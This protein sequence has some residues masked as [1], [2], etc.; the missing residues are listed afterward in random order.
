M[1]AGQDP[2]ASQ[3]PIRV[4]PL[5]ETADLLEA[6]RLQK[7]VWGFSDI[8]LLPPRL[9]VV[10]GKI[11]GQVLGAFDGERMAGFCLAIPGLKPGGKYYLHSHMLGVMEEYQNR[12]IGRMLKL[13]QRSEALERAIE[14]IEWT[15]DPLEIKN[16]HFNLQRLGAIVRRYVPNQYGVSSSPL[17]GGLPTDRCVAE[18]WVSSARVRSILEGGSPIRYTIER[19]IEVPRRIGDWKRT[20]PEQARQIQTRVREEFEHWLGRGLAVVG[21]ESAPAGGAFLLGPPPAEARP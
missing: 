3:A 9:F 16:S 12:G 18:W 20:D 19:R 10:A 21:Y 15:F 2:L 4:R 11:G 1:A 17:H 8:D 7:M 5:V 6:V 14:L 13:A